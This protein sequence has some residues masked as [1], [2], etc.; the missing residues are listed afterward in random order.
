[1]CMFLCMVP[2]LGLVAKYFAWQRDM[3]GFNYEANFPNFQILTTNKVR[4]RKLQLQK[5]H[6]KS[7]THPLLL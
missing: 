4:D 1:M 3:G 6:F 2:D 5:S 7:T